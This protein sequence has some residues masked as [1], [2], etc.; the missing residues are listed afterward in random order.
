MKKEGY[1]SEGYPVTAGGQ[2]VDESTFKS[3]EQYI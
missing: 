1:D 3:K 2:R